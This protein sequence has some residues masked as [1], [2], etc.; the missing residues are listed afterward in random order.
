MSV[1]I[2]KVIP[3]D[4]TSYGV[5]DSGAIDIALRFRVVLSEPLPQSK[6]FTTFSDGTTSVPSIGSAHPDRPGYYAA[7]YDVTQPEGAAKNTLEVTVKYEARDYTT[8]GSGQDAHVSNIES[9]GWDDATAQRELVTD[10]SGDT[11]LNSAGDPFDT[12]PQIET[13]A[14]TFTK[15]VRFGSR[16]SGWASYFCTVNDA[17]VTIGGIS[18][19]ARTLLCTISEVKDISNPNWPYKYTVRLRYRSNMAKI[20]LAETAEEC[21]WDIVICDAGMREVDDTTGQLKLIQTIS[22]E[23]GQPA[24]VTTPELLDGDGHAIARTA[25]VSPTPYNFRF[26]SYAEASFPDWFTSEPV[27][28]SNATT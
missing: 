5:N 12:V 10:A 17:A 21:G 25:G 14:P 3:R 23:T 9:W 1:L 11:V 7:R 2:T 13:P 19:A 27:I 16:Q 26:E 24:T 8:E 4:G 15:V 28:P 22:H 6:L 18:F 20:A